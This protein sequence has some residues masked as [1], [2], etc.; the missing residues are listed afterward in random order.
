MLTKDQHSA[1]TSNPP[2]CNP[3]CEHSIP[4]PS[5]PHPLHPTQHLTYSMSHP[6]AP[7]FPLNRAQEKSRK[8]AAQQRLMKQEDA[9]KKRAAAQQSEYLRDMKPSQRKLI[10]WGDVP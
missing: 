8:V 7:R 4:A 1:Q 2:R 6:P 10:E 3:P 5:I 9:A